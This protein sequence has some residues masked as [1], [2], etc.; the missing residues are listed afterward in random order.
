MVDIFGPLF[1]LTHAA[2]RAVGTG[3]AYTLTKAF[4]EE[5]KPPAPRERQPNEA[6]FVSDDELKRR[7]IVDER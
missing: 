7:G 5:P 3:I 6:D 4:E 2:G 1:Q